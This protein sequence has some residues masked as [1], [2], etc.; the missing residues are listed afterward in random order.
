MLQYYLAAISYIASSLFFEFCVNSTKFGNW[1]HLPTVMKIVTTL[2][3]PCGPR[4]LHHVGP[5]CRY[6]VDPHHVM[7]HQHRMD[8]H[9]S[10]HVSFIGQH[11]SS[12]DWSETC[13]GLINDA[14]IVIHFVK[15]WQNYVYI[16]SDSI[17]RQQY[18]VKIKCDCMPRWLSFS[19]LPDAGLNTGKQL[20]LVVSVNGL[21]R[22]Y[23]IPNAI[24]SFYIY[25][26][27][28]ISLTA[29]STWAV[30]SHNT[31]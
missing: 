20:S 22:R 12:F 15:Q 21:R 26:T 3:A 19:L 27:H 5:T 8:P 31:Q 17:R 25:S 28:L 14:I 1:C 24:F 11:V 4:C 18:S 13:D 16:A 10:N 23:N 2:L 9:E 29:T 30:S 7:P 6:L